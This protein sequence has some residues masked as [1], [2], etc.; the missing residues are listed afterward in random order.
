MSG[1]RLNISS[2]S[3][4]EDII[5]YSRAVR[6]GDVVEVSGTTAV[7]DAGNLVGEGD[8]YAQ[9]KFALGKIEKALAQAGATLRDVVKTRVYA[10]DI[11]RWQDI[12]KAHGE[13]FQGIKPATVILEVK[14]LIDSKMLVEIEA[15][16]VLGGK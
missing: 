7:D 8:A 3:K 11:S 2:G 12:G 13:I 14:A 10:V 15:T 1:Q 6:V 4:W 16:A 5:G 9:T